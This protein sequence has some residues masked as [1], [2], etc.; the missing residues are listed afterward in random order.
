MALHLMDWAAIP[1]ATNTPNKVAKTRPRR[2]HVNG[3]GMTWREMVGWGLAVYVASP[4]LRSKGGTCPNGGW[5]GLLG[6]G[7]GV[8]LHR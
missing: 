6:Y 2:D 5:H 1:A 3:L 4:L 7:S 8:G